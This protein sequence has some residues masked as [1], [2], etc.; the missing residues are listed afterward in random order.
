MFKASVISSSPRFQ[1]ERILPDLDHLTVQSGLI[2]RQT[3]KFSAQGF[4][5]APLKSVSTGHASLGQM[6]A[7][8]A[9]GTIDRVQKSHEATLN[10]TVTNVNDAPAFTANPI[11]LPDATQGAAYR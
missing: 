9:A 10:I 11:N 4:L 2:V 1:L 5:L 3:S 6:D 7:L 8:A